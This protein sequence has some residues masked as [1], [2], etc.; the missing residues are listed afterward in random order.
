MKKFGFPHPLVLL[1]AFILICALLSYIIPSG[2]YERIEDEATGRNIVVSGSYKRVPPSP[3]GFFE[4]IVAIPRG[5]IEASDVI[6]LVFLIGGAFTVVD[7]TKALKKGVSFLTSNFKGK[8]SYIIIII[9]IAFATG[10]V[11]ENMQEE[12]IALIPV[13]LILTNSLGFK[14]MVT[15][16]MSVGP[17][18]IGSSFSP[19]NPFQV[20]IAQKIAELPLLS[21]SG[22]RMIFLAIALAIWIFW[23]LKY[24]YKTKTDP[25]KQNN[26]GLVEE[27][28][29]R[30]YL[31]LGLVILTFG[32][33]TFGILKL[34]WGFNQLSA[35][36][37]I[38]GIV[39]GL[40]GN[41][42]INGTANAFISGF[43]EMTYAALLIGFARAIYVVL[44]DG[45]IIDTI[46]YS[47]FTPIES[48][49][50]QLSAIGMMVAHAF[51]HIPVP[52]VSGQAVLTMPLLIPL[53]DLIGLSR[54]VAVLA[55]QFGA[56]LTDLVTPTNGALMALLA[57]AGVNY[58]D[59]FKFVIK[60]Y[61]ILL[62]L[63]ALAMVIA[64][65]IGLQ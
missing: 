4:A 61:L 12:I 33:I 25:T 62:G 64:I 21:G 32:L 20:G 3:V 50:V 65:K 29:F 46:V 22:F 5:M 27:F 63:G 13:L 44:E 56:G 31:I 18:F 1:M 35:A 17:A 10:G 59:W 49:P 39:V 55:Y 58:D 60:K 19:I 23:T 6:F 47:I 16:S 30:S 53:S 9:S 15:L 14:P 28:D 43:R 51:I 11:L 40:V 34:H 37:F 57:A 7:R 42:G 52:S 8:E 41:L 45:R 54:Q 2:Q 26:D 38:M 36:F 48:L 24:A